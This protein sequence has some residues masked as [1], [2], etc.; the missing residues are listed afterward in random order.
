MP[1]FCC[2]SHRSQKGLKPRPVGGCGGRVGPPHIGLPARGQGGAGSE[3]TAGEGRPSPSM[4]SVSDGGGSNPVSRS[5]KTAQ[6]GSDAPLLLYGPSK[7]KGIEA[8]TGRRGSGERGG[9]PDQMPARARAGRGRERSD[10]RGGAA[11]PL[12]GER[13]RRRGFES[14]FPLHENRR[15]GPKAPLGVWVLTAAELSRR[16]RWSPSPPSALISQPSTPISP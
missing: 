16:L 3:A 11:E 12:L 14:R 2:L 5:K 13:Q 7:V 6:R 1:L 10:R 4:G 8:A 15:E 9:S